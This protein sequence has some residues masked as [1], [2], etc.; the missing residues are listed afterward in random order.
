MLRPHLLLVFPSLST[1]VECLGAVSLDLFGS[2]SPFNSYRS[3]LLCI[4]M[5][6]HGSESRCETAEENMVVAD[7]AR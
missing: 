1:C 7:S 3:E 5:R 6:Q 2:T 4:L